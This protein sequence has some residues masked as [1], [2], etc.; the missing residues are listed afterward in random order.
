MK[1]SRRIVA[2]LCGQIVVALVLQPA[3]LFARP[4]NCVV[5]QITDTTNSESTRP[6]ISGNGKHIAFVSNADLTGNNTDRNFEVFLFDLRT[7]KFTQITDTTSNPN[8]QPSLNDRGTLVA[9]VSTADLSGSNSDHNQEIFLYETAS[10]R[11]IQITDSIA[12]FNGDPDLSG[13]GQAIVFTSNRDLTGRNADGNFEVFLSQVGAG[14]FTQITDTLTGFNVVPAADASATR[15]SFVSSSDLTGENADANQEIFLFNTKTKVFTQVTHSHGERNLISAI[16]ANGRTIA[17]AS[18]ADLTGDNPDES[19]EIFLFDV[20][21]NTLQQVTD[22]TGGFSFSPSIDGRGQLVA[23]VSDRDLT[24]NNSDGNDEIF[25]FNSR[26]GNFT[27]VTATIGGQNHQ[28]AIDHAG[29]RIVFISDRDL[30]GSNFDG[31]REVFLAECSA[32]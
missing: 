14:N 24:G 9:F 7:G 5:I 3:G 20:R 25:V 11:I 27:Q 13:D 21:T 17:L 6:A 28:P 30:T 23:F 29:R 4:N 10:G 8:E 15:I 31:N 22:T 18:T 12:G 32:F 1:H 26:T 16:S 2:S 19:Q